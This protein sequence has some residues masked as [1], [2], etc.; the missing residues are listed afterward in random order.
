MEL[1]VR[2]S[3]KRF[4]GPQGMGVAGKAEVSAPSVFLVWLERVLRRMIRRRHK[5]SPR[6]LRPFSLEVWSRWWWSTSVGN[7]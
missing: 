3:R 7:R 5:R 6:R 1:G 4:T 2:C